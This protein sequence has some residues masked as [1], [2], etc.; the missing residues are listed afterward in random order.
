MSAYHA[1]G[2]LC[3]VILR[4]AVPLDQ[5]SANR[6]AHLAW[7][8]DELASGRVL[9]AGRQ[10]PLTGGVLLY[11]GTRAQVEPHASADPFVREGIAHIEYIEIATGFAQPEV[12]PFIGGGA[13]S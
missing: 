5:V 8:D 11:R 7:L 13:T 2:P 9:L 6:D 4:Y 10:N 12:A 1:S 3:L